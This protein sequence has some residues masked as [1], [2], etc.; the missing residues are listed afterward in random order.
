MRIIRKNKGKS[1]VLPLLL[2]ALI[3]LALPLFSCNTEQTSTS[4][5]T[6]DPTVTVFRLKEDMAL[7]TKITSAKFEELTLPASQVTIGAISDISTAVGK[8]ARVDLEAGDILV[9]SDISEEKPTPPKVKVELENNDFGFKD[10]N[11]IVVTEFVT[12]NTGKD[13]S[14]ELRSIIT[15]AANGKSVIYFPD[16]EYVISQPLVTSSFGTFSVALKFSPNARLKA[17]DDWDKSQGA[18]IQLGGKDESYDIDV[19]GANYYVEGGIIDG[20]GRANGIS[21]ECGREASIRNLTIVN[22]VTGLH[23]NNFGNVVDSDAEN[24]KIIGNG[25]PGSV[26]LKIQGSDSTFTNIRISN[27]QTGVHIYSPAHILRNI[28]VTYVSNPRLDMAYNL[29]YGFKSE[30][31]RCWFD[32]CISEGFSTAFVLSNRG[33]TL[34]NCIATWDEVYGN[35]V[36]LSTGYRSFSAVVR[37]F[38]ANFTAPKEQCEYLIAP[39]GGSGY[40][41]DPLFDENAVNGDAYKEYLRSSAT[42]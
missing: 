19:L 3:L 5:L 2:C 25:E 29:S 41:Y 42:K 23:F 11:R 26:G 15:K 20:N 10:Y 30:D 28:R 33:D 39:E 38:V 14:N 37:S 4:E 17:S 32:T 7:G 27:V 21:I 31:H 9:D 35:Q 18:M 34:Q 24:I 13:V 1:R 6:D 36:A 16:G 12:P 8:Y 22:T 40:I